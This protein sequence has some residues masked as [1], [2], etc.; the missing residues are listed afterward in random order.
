MLTQRFDVAAADRALT[1]ES[2]VQAPAAAARSAQG[3][4]RRASLP[5][6]RS[7]QPDRDRGKKSSH[8]CDRDSRLDRA[9]RGHVGSRRAR[10][11]RIA[12]RAICAHSWAHRR[13]RSI[14]RSTSCSTRARRRRSGAAISGRAGRALPARA[15]GAKAKALRRPGPRGPARPAS[16]RSRLQARRRQQTQRRLETVVAHAPAAG[17]HADR[18]RLDLHARITSLQMRHRVAHRAPVADDV[19]RR[20][21]RQRRRDR[22]QQYFRGVIDVGPVDR[23]GKVGEGD[24][25]IAAGEAFDHFLRHAPAALS[26][27]AVHP[28][29]AQRDERRVS[30]QGAE[31]ACQ[32]LAGR[33]G[34]AVYGLRPQRDVVAAAFGARADRG[35]RAREDD[36]PR[37]CRARRREHRAVPTTLTRA[38][39]S[40]F[41]AAAS[42]SKAARCTTT[43]GLAFA[44][45]AASAVDI[46]D[47]APNVGIAGKIDGRDL[48]PGAA[49]AQGQRVTEEAGA[50]G[51]E[52]PHAIST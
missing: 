24:A 7:D 42:V 28:A 30:G 3:H 27:R 44:I 36:A 25:R 45:A 19:E 8:R 32:M 40:G 11:R 4:R 47:I 43:S 12:G 20:V 15:A 21:P 48:V 46:G 37:R 52:R 9:D 51:D 41:S 38:A 18:L 33:L 17:R 5:R 50:S 16:R 22:A 35:D 6:R 49:R 13:R 2:A 10:R 26:S 39:A 31:R 1:S 14:R 29:E 34:R 23:F